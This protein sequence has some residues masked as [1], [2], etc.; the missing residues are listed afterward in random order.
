MRWPKQTHCARPEN[1]DR[2]RLT[3]WTSGDGEIQKQL[4]YIMISKKIKTWL[5]C[6]KAKGTDNAHHANQ[7]NIISMEIRVKLKR[8][9][10]R[11][12]R[13]NTYIST[14]TNSE[15]TPRNYESGRIVRKE[16]K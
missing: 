8:K 12:N 2:Q 11:T 10:K 3:T 4:D 7:H 15:I 9:K 13:T 6:S 16:G 1:N 14:S 5:N